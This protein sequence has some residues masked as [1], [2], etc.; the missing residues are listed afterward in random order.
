MK[1]TYGKEIPKSMVVWS[2]T[3]FEN[4]FLNEVK[5]IRIRLID[6]NIDFVK[7]GSEC[8]D[9]RIPSDSR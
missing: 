6:R 1:I 2:C 4:D 5:V 8:D 3:K 9:C 7:K